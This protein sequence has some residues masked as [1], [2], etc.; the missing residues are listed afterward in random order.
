M[1]KSNIHPLAFEAV[2]FKEKLMRNGLYATGQKMEHVVSQIGWE[3]AEL[4]AKDVWAK[5]VAFFKKN[6]KYILYSL[7]HDDTHGFSFRPGYLQKPER[8]S[9]AHWR[10]F[11]EEKTKRD[12]QLAKRKKK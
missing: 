8:W 1:K 2:V 4:M 10:W 9:S 3:L 6:K 7:K 5:G 12:R 11:I